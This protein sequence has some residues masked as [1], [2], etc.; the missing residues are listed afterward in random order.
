[1]RELSGKTAVITGGASGIGLA[2][3]KAALSAQMKV[4]I[5]DI[6]EAALAQAQEELA[7]GDNVLGV[8]ADVCDSQKMQS[9]SEQV[10]QHFCLTTLV[11]AAAICFGKPRKKTG[12]GCWA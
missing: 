2:L 7:G 1:M 5:V 4:V 12:T 6:E 8:Q 9:L 10:Q 3:A 11:S